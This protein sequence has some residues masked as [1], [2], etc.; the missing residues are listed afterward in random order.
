MSITRRSFGHLPDGT[1]VDELTLSNGRGLSLSVINLGGI[2]TSIHCP[3]REGRRANVVL[4][5]DN[6]ADYVERNPSFGVIAGRYANRIAGGRFVLDGQT[7]ALPVNDPPN[8]LH[9]GP[10]GFGHRWWSLNPLPSTGDGTVAVEL[11]LTS[12]DGD[13]GFPGRLQVDVRYTLTP[14]NIWRIDY[15]ATTDRP[16][17][18]NLTNH[19]YFNLA[20]GGTALDHELRLHAS[21]YTTIDERLIPNGIADVS[22]TP[23]DFR[24]AMRVG[25]RI[26]DGVPQLM[27]ARGYDHNFIIDRA[28]GTGLALA[29]RLS[30]PVSGR[31]LEVETTEPA[32]QFYA[33]NSLDGRLRGRG[34][35][36]YRQGDGLCLE[37]QHYP[38]APNQ[39]AF[40]STVLRPGDTFTSSTL[41]R[42]LTLPARAG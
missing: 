20:G 17:V 2:V 39:P 42:F 32:V 8:T 41:Y 14:D 7:F 28:A 1:A 5:F 25:E 18:L 34:G 16:T 31:V 40:P 11:S 24:V 19:S 26:R 23:F 37:T 12:D 30:D 22:G 9:G 33:G 4:G 27:R 36:C 10:H 38:D 35:K 21:R 13:A 3:D 6:L 15:R 29:A